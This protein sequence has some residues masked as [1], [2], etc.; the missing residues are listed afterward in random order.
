M[1]ELVYQAYASNLRDDMCKFK[2]VYNA[3]TNLF[4]SIFFIHKKLTEKTINVHVRMLN[5]AQYM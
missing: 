2:S 5:I 4:I 1:Y 3:K